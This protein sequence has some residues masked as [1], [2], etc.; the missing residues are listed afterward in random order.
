M[1]L[2]GA[3]AGL[4]KAGKAAAA[5]IA[6]GEY[7]REI[8]A[9]L[10]KKGEAYEPLTGID[11]EL[12]AFCLSQ[13]GGG[14]LAWAINERLHGRPYSVEKV[15]S[16]DN[17][18][19]CKVLERGLAFESF[20]RKMASGISQAVDLGKTIT[21]SA[22][23]E[24]HLVKLAEQ[25]VGTAD[26]GDPRFTRQHG[27]VDNATFQALTKSAAVRMSGLSEHY[28][29]RE[30]AVLRT[31][32]SAFPSVR[33]EKVA[34][35]VKVD[36]LLRSLPCRQLE[37]NGTWMPIDTTKQASEALDAAMSYPDDP[38]FNYK[39]RMILAKHPEIRRERNIACF[40]KAGSAALFHNDPY[41]LGLCILG[42]A[43]EGVELCQ[44]K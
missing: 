26:L 35:E 27:L 1:G 42:L 40:Q 8:P 16:G 14:R 29:S 28:G 11:P 30:T 31:A 36:A 20:L 34:A 10:L 13:G 33:Q 41:T 17:Q 32:R 15:A 25:V 21:K 18:E 44:S 38:D 12:T 3:A 37:V 7:L 9:D 19:F 5:S 4:D 22:S 39:T 23:V 43:H 24:D 6:A 2:P